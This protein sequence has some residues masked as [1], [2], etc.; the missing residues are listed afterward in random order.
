[1]SPSCPCATPSH[2]QGEGAADEAIAHPPHPSLCF[3]KRFDAPATLLPQTPS[4][5]FR[6]PPLPHLPPF[7]SHIVVLPTRAIAP[8]PLTRIAH[9]RHAASRP[10]LVP[11]Y[12]ML[13]VSVGRIFRG[14]VVSGSSFV[15]CTLLRPRPSPH[16]ATLSV[17][18]NLWTR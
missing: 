9:L 3:G 4:Y 1:M 5:P 18:I 14:R 17:S 7:P 15:V 12:C 13:F 16:Q 6:R 2:G 11:P 8:L 10:L